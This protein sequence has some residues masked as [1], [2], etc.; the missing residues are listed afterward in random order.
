MVTVNVQRNADIAVAAQLRMMKSWLDTA[1]IKV[2]HLW[3][4]RV[5]PG[6]ITVSGQFQSKADADRFRAQFEQSESSAE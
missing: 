6:R 5:F 4:T 2:S 3:A 1:E